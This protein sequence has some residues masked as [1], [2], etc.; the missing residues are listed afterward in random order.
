MLV[1]YQTVR[2]RGNHN[3]GLKLLKWLLSCHDNQLVL[4]FVY[5]HSCRV[6][7]L[8]HL[9]SSAIAIVPAAARSS[10]LH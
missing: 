9:S 8:A 1:R 2:H 4:R 5:A 6:V 7:S 3:E 10:P